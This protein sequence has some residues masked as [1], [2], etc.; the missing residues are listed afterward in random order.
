MNS[1]MGRREFVGLSLAMAAALRAD[2]P[3]INFPTAARKRLAVST[4]PFRSVIVSLHRREGA[5]GKAHMSLQDFAAT[6]P[7]KFGVH[8]IEPWSPHFVSNDSEYVHSLKESFDKSGLHVVNIP[9]DSGRPKL[10]GTAEERE[11]GLAFYRKWVDAAVILQ[12]PGIRVHMPHAPADKEIECAVSAFKTLADYG[13]SKNIVISIENDEAETEKPEAIV[14]VITGVNS[15]FLRSLPDFCNS[16]AIH[17]DQSYNEQA[18][19]ALFPLAYNISHVKDSEGG[20]GGKMFHVNVDKIFAIA[21][22]AGYRGY[23]SIEWEGAGNDPYAG[24]QALLEASLRN[25]S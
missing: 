1:P 4:Y 22:Q 8:G 9:V 2:E 25:L 12:S 5:S 6:I 23:F 11:A 20:E 7:T 18:M 17:D 19:R 15:P 24:T 16:M 3:K 13:A 10:C 14:K 21:K